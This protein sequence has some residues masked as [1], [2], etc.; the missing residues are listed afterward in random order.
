MFKSTITVIPPT[1]ET[2]TDSV[3]IYF[4]LQ[5]Y[6]NPQKHLPFHVLA[7]GLNILHVPI[8][9]TPQR[10]LRKFSRKLVSIHYNQ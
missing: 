2:L 7:Q 4:K 10:T 1:I 5:A 9:P 6:T 3:F 8:K